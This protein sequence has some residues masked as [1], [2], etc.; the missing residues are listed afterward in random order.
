MRK[1]TEITAIDGT[2]Q[3]GGEPCGPSIA[4]LATGVGVAIKAIAPLTFLIRR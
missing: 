3:A 1:E 4:P 2:I